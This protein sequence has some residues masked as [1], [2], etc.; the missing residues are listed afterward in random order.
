MRIGIFS[1]CYEPILNGVVVSIN[2]FVRELEKR[3]HKCFIFAPGNRKCT[4]FPANVYRFPAIAW[5]KDYP[6]AF[7]FLAPL[8]SSKICDLNLDIIHTQHMFAM[9]RLG[10]KIGKQ[11]NIPVVHT[12]HTLITEYAHYIPLVPNNVVKSIVERITRSYCNQCDQ[13]VTPSVS[14]QKILRDYGVRTPI[15][16][17]PTGIYLDEFNHPFHKDVLRA[18]WHIPE[19]QKVLLYL[20]RVAKEKNLDFLFDAIKKL[21]KKRDDFHLLLVGGGPELEYYKKIVD[22]WELSAFVTFTGMQ[23]KESANRFFGAA[24]LFVFPSITETQGIVITEAMA[25]GI[26][27]VA[28]NKMGPSNIVRDGIDGF[29]TALN[30]D[31]FSDKIE[32]L[33][34]DSSLR[35]KMGKAAR[36]NAEN[37]SAENSATKMEKLY[38]R[39]IHYYCSK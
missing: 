10:L 18:K 33:L 30:V 19:N 4:S 15:E 35:E 3:G 14:M 12:Y 13:I 26:P 24:D 8:K 2:T 6:L 29:L 31:E 21:R 28:I 7:P 11:C 25:A 16:A 36:K 5:P 39:T 34:N 32:K 23:K 37:Y 17:I 38:E 9:G 1:E 27:A 22:K 20:S